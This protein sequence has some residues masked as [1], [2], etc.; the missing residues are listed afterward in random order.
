[1]ASE[2]VPVSHLP[3]WQRA[4]GAQY[5][6]DRTAN[7]SKSHIYYLPAS[8]RWA[9]VKRRDAHHVVIS[10]YNVCPCALTQA[11]A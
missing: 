9:L 7:P 2:V 1:M 6:A 5:R 3:R 8:K 11:S 10:Y 4:H